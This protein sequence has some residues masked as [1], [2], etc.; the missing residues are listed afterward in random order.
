MSDFQNL[1]DEAHLN[2]TQHGFWHGLVPKDVHTGLIKLALIT[3]EVGE[4]VEAL[5]TKDEMGFGEELADIVIRV[6]DLAGAWDL[7]LAEII[8]AKQAKNRARPYLHGKLA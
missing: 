6:M 1:Q 3:S 4:A 8:C 5:R 7:N 2:S